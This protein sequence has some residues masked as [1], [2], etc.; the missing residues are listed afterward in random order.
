MPAAMG[1]R[2][3]EDP[4]SAVYEAH[5]AFVWRSVRRLGVPESAVAD[6]VQDV[7]L[8]V[9]RQLSAFRG[10]CSVRSWLFAIASRVVRDSRRTLHRKPGHLGGR[11]RAAQDVDLVVDA[12]PNPQE[13]AAA[14]EAVS[15][16]HAVLAS[17]SKERRE[18]FI[19]AELEE[20][21]VADIAAAVQ[22]NANT[23]YSR[24]R[25]AR[26]EFERAVARAR[27]SDQWRIR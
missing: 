22:S 16:L 12:R 23:V 1:S 5:F 8:I 19:L 26:A 21:S 17:M 10:D 6:A 18:V 7:F 2:A 20:M 9:H 14:G 25:A 27:A 24:L 15:T 4:F 3:A 11:G 13:T